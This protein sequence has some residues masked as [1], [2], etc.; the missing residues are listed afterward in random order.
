MVTVVTATG[1]NVGGDP[2][3]VVDVDLSLERDIVQN[4]RIGDNILKHS[5]VAIPRILLTAVEFF[6]QRQTIVV[7][8][9][10][11]LQKDSQ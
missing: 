11:Y 10:G 5:S 3:D 9:S 4:Q 1:F 2:S 7:V 8:R 6:E